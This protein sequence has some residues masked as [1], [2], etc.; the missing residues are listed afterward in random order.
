MCSQPAPAQHSFGLPKQSQQLELLLGFLSQGAFLHRLL[1][2]ITR[3]W[4][5]E[6]CIFSDTLCSWRN[7]PNDCDCVPHDCNVSW[8]FQDVSF[9]RKGISTRRVKQL[10]FQT[11]GLS[12]ALLDA[13]EAWTCCL[14]SDSRW[15]KFTPMDT[16][17]CSAS[18]R[19]AAKNVQMCMHEHPR[20]GMHMPYTCVPFYFRLFIF[21]IP[22]FSPKACD[23]PFLLPFLSTTHHF[24]DVLHP[25][26]RFSIA[27]KKKNQTCCLLI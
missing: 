2:P 12:F 9:F 13:T 19:S 18:R 23:T 14:V 25:S 15:P 7:T 20:S 4:C 22:I 17:C 21:P 27:S 26:A 3:K 10:I 24:R 16:C 1:H 6:P 8:H 5:C 11:W